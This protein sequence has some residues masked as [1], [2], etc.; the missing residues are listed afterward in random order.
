LI[1]FPATEEDEQ[2]TG[3]RRSFGTWATEAESALEFDR[4]VEES[5]LFERVFKEVRGFY[6]SYRPN[7]QDREA[8][9]DRIL[10]PGRRLREAGWSRVIGV[11]LKKSGEP[12]GKPLAQAIDYMFCAWNV[13]H[14]WMLVEHVFL[15]PYQRQHKAT[16]SVMLQNSVG[17]ANDGYGG[18]LQFQLSGNAI[19]ID[20]QGELRVRVPACG[21]KVGSR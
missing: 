20:R 15:W 18:V 10:L 12:I 5:G 13:G 9:I 11:E 17:V 1:A 3:A 2:E 4:R 16:E 21:L 19:S 8:R 7:R 14:Y 6:L